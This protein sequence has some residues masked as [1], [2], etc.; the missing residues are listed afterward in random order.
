MMVELTSNF[1]TYKITWFPSFRFI[2][3][4]NSA[5]YL[6]LNYVIASL[7][8]CSRFTGIDELW[9]VFTTSVGIIY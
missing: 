7:F 5:S 8:C 2:C 1:V 6:W 9:T 3:P 4:E